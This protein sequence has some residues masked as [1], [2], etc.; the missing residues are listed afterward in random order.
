[1]YIMSNKVIAMPATDKREAYIQVQSWTKPEGG[2]WAPLKD[3][4]TGATFGWRHYYPTAQV[5]EERV[6]MTP[7]PAASI[8]LD[9]GV[10]WTPLK[11]AD[12]TTWVSALKGDT[13]TRWHIRREGGKLLARKAK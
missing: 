4:Q 2:P 13:Y 8:S 10:T 7:P 11:G 12:E 9:G 3:K 1:M 6:G 5:V